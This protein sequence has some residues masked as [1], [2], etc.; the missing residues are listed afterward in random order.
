MLAQEQVATQEYPHP[1]PASGVNAGDEVSE[2]EAMK[3]ETIQVILI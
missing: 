3:L 2:L 1:A